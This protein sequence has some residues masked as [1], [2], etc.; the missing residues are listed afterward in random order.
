MCVFT[1]SFRI[2]AVLFAGCGM[3][4]QTRPGP[5]TSCI[6][7]SAGQSECTSTALSPNSG[8]RREV[9]VRSFGAV[10]DGTNDQ[11]AKIQAAVDYLRA[12]GGGTLVIP[13]ARNCYAVET[14][15]QLY[16]DMKVRIEKG[17]CLRLINSVTA[18]CQIF[19]C[20]AVFYSDITS[21]PRNI[22]ISGAGLI[23]G[24]RVNSPGIASGGAADCVMAIGWIASSIEG[25]TCKD[26][27]ADGL[28]LF[29][30]GP[31]PKYGP[32][33][34]RCGD[35]ILIS[36]VTVI[37]AS[38]NGIT[39]DGGT[40]VTIRNSRLAYT[41]GAAPEAGLDVEPDFPGQYVTGLTVINTEVDHNA[42]PQAAEIALNF[43]NEP[44]A[45][46]RLDFRA[47]D[48]A[49]YGLDI[50]AQRVTYSGASITGRYTN[51]GHGVRSSYGLVLDSGG[52]DVQVS[53]KSGGSEFGLGCF[54]IDN[55]LLAGG[56]LSGSVSDFVNSSCT[57]V[58]R[59]G[60]TFHHKA[61]P[62]RVRSSLPGS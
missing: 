8:I 37:A 30:A 56:T 62:D 27:P 49:L 17:A 41:H 47:H 38:R 1:L 34:T 7:A 20:R 60:M 22:H 23:D 25:I 11:S 5:N 46:F 48:N 53:I 35:Q 32:G 61:A 9:S 55:L 12:E 24:N 29:C 59:G 54:G 43:T 26:A 31:N 16:S 51:N 13:K 14:G 18:H 6:P 4:A 52:S 39:I 42:G 40:H 28:A 57:N 50:S 2:S 10:D 36:H 45:D 19:G 15:I 44:H 3:L 33:N 21:N 58:K